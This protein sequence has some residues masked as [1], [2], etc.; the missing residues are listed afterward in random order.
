MNYTPILALIHIT[1][2][3]NLHCLHCYARKCK[4]TLTY[5][6]IAKLVDELI[7]L[8]TKMIHL[9]GG[10]ILLH[11]DIYKIISYINHKQ[12]Y[13]EITTNGTLLDK[14]AAMELS[15]LQI[16][17]IVISFDG[18]SAKTHD[19]IRGKGSFNKSLKNLEF[20]LAK[21]L[22]MAVNFT[23]MKRN[24]SEI[25]AFIDRFSKYDLKFINFRRF[26][27][28]GRGQFKNES[29]TAKQ[30]LE[31]FLLINK[32]RKNDSRI[33][34]GGEPHRAIL[35]PV[36][37]KKAKTLNISGCSAGKFFISID[38]NGD[39]MP[40]GFIP[41]A[42]GNIK[43]ESIKEIWTKSRLLMQLRDRSNLQDKC[44]RCPHKNICGGCRA[45]AYATNSNI[46]GTDPLCWINSNT[47]TK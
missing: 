11:K 22:S 45:S 1:D 37:N 13:L 8:G 7:T 17:K 33:A 6:E 3:C 5:T 30:Y 10:E 28:I 19:A 31:L 38:P 39:V 26:I 40:C 24:Y 23:V 14:H 20:A 12:L 42:V 35:D 2:E 47:H 9:S 27:P 44:G 15:K 18:A 16:N 43:K 4:N 25:P 29:I 41:L 32:K 36:L 21:N 34:L 46:M